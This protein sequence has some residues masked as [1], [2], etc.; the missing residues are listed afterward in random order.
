MM[1]NIFG[2]I[3]EMELK[4]PMYVT[5][6]GGWHNQ[7]VMR[8]EKGFPDYQWIQ[9]LGGSGQLTVN[10]SKYTVSDGQGMLLFPH[11]KHEYGPLKEPWTVRW[12]S[13]NG[14]C[15]PGLLESIHFEASKVLYLANPDITLAVMHSIVTALQSENPL[16]GAE[17]SS[18]AYELLLDLFIHAS[19]SEVRSKQQHMAQLSPVFALIE[20]KYDQTISLQEMADKLGVTPQHTCLLFQQTMG[21]RPF[22]YLTRYRLRKAKELLLQQLELEVRN[23]ARQ[24]GYEDCSYFIKLFKQQEG[25][26][27]SS[28]RKIHRL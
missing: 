4:L 21:I 11:V 23:V 19:S 26:T 24:V 10:I 17:C 7:N 6:A 14:A 27:P 5:S 22:A 20:E 18:L 1:M 16:R 25:I 12:V 15:M 2:I 8:R 9:T 13:F 3:T 28:F